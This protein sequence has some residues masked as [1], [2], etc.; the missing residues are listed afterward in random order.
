MFKGIILISMLLVSS[1]AMASPFLV[2]DPSEQAIGI[3]YEIYENQSLLFAGQNEPDGSIKFDLAN[4]SIGDHQYEVRYVR[5]D[6]I[7]GNAYSEFVPFGFSRPSSAVG[8]TGGLK[9]AP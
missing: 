3:G 7:W 6:D 4:V 1:V 9:L 2:S 8:N 5:H